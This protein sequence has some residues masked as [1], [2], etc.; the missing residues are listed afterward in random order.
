MTETSKN[1][2]EARRRRDLA[3]FL[4]A[5]RACLKPSDFGLPSLGRRRA[6]GLRREELAQIS[7]IGISWYT[8]LEQGRD[9]QVSKDLLQRLTSA[10]RLSPHDA[11]Y[12]SSLASHPVSE[13][14]DSFAEIL[15]MLQIALDGFSAGPAFVT[16]EA[17]DVMAFNGLGNFIYRFDTYDGPHAENIA[18][19]L[20]MDPYRRGIFA[21]WPEWAAL[22]V[23][24][25]R[26]QCARLSGNKRLQQL[27]EDLLDAS[28]EFGQMWEA[29]RKSGAGSYVPS[30][31]RFNIAD[32]GILTF[33]SLRLR[34]VTNPDWLLVQL[35]PADAKTACAVVEIRAGKGK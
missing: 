2:A 28:P 22:S 11:A 29:S 32:F 24:I 6:P 21:A 13:V 10:L 9:I 18:W 16:D 30:E 26:A 4:K 19:R 27:V 1:N 12:L 8:S 5:K 15:P 7:G 34:I 35:I 17:F 14:H 20:F 31:I 33:L 3:E 25:L 23:G